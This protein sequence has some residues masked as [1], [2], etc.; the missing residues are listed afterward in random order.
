MEEAAKG[1]GSITFFANRKQALDFVKKKRAHRK[2]IEDDDDI[3]EEEE[4]KTA[5]K[6]SPT[7][8]PTR[9]KRNPTTATASKQP[10]ATS[11]NKKKK[12]KQQESDNE[13]T[14]LKNEVNHKELQNMLRKKIMKSQGN[15]ANM[16]YK[17]FPEQNSVVVVLDYFRETTV[18]GETTKRVSVFHLQMH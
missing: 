11:Q 13:E 6:V 8:T 1:E 4:K 10:S 2:A 15:K 12:P 17:P 5:A 7:N 9:R 16:L 14:N 18:A 3:T